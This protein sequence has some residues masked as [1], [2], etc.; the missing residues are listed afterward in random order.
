MQPSTQVTHIPE[1][2]EMEPS[3]RFLVRV[4]AD[5]LSLVSVNDT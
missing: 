2:E 3:V 5:E 1:I 4:A